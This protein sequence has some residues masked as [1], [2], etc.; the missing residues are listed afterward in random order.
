[1]SKAHTA[2][3]VCVFAILHH[4]RLDVR[5]PANNKFTQLTKHWQIKVNV[6]VLQQPP[7]T[8]LAAPDRRHTHTIM[9][10]N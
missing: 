2:A 4:M 5:S 3:C 9:H 1:M 10:S 7:N 6:K 8:Y